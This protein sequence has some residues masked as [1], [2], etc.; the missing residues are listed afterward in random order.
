MGNTRQAA[1]I[2]REYC[3]IRRQ[4]DLKVEGECVIV[5]LLGGGGVSNPGANWAKSLVEGVRKLDNGINIARGDNGTLKL[6]KE[7]V[8]PRELIQQLEE[9]Q[10]GTVLHSLRG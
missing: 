9:M 6:C 3:N 5:R 2:L 10:V 7:G 1:K 8:T 4:L